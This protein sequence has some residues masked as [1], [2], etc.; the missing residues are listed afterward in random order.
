MKNNF[1]EFLR[2]GGED[3]VE[4]A[5]T[6]DDTFDPVEWNPVIRDAPGNLDRV[7]DGSVLNHHS[8]RI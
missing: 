2:G 3:V 4:L 5:L 8:F 7:D 6:V 1:I